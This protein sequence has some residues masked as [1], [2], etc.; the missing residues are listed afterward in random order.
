MNRIISSQYLV[1]SACDNSSS[2]SCS[3]SSL[4]NRDSRYPRLFGGIVRCLCSKHFIKVS[5]SMSSNKWWMI[6]EQNKV[7]F[8]HD[9]L[10]NQKW[11]CG[12]LL[13]ESEPYRP[14]SHDTHDYLRILSVF[15]LTD[16]RIHRKNENA[17]FSFQNMLPSYSGQID[18]T[19]FFYL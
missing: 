7:L 12:F 9:H 19:L 2:F 6:H 16:N 3:W 5:L 1:Q 8:S 15:H 10:L 11:F 14:L 4:S 17:L 18:L 13:W